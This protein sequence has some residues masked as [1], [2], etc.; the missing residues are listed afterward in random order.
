MRFGTAVPAETQLRTLRSLDDRV[1]E[2]ILVITTRLP[3]RETAQLGV[4]D[5]FALGSKRLN[6]IE[7]DHNL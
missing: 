7:G 2:H 5:I 6:V 3:H 4:L 1:E